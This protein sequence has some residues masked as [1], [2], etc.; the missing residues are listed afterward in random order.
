MRRLYAAR[1]GDRRQRE[2]ARGRAGEQRQPVA[3][4]RREKLVRQRRAVG[5]DRA[6]VHVAVDSDAASVDDARPSAGS[7]QEFEKVERG[8]EID[9]LY[10]DV[11]I[12]RW[13]RMTGEQATHGERGVDIAAV[14]LEGSEV[15]HER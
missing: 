13:Q 9:P 4:H 14:E 5:A 3:R 10:V 6:S 12:R 7:R 1:G 15:R 8:V 11:A 2:L